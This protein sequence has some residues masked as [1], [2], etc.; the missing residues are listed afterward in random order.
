MI[1]EFQGKYRWLSNFYPCKIVLDGEDYNTVEHAYQAAKV[2]KSAVTIVRIGGKNVEKRVRE[3]VGETATPGMAKKLGKR[4]NLRTDW[5]VVKVGIMKDLLR[6]K[7]S[8][9]PFRSQLLATGNCQLVE[10]NY[11]G[12]TYWGVCN[13]KGENILGNL[14]MT[15]RNEIQNNKWE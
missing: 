11:W 10:G 8:Q 12:D 6:Q 2:D 13:G 3:L 1:S 7:F 15:I 5:E 4:L 14:I 9:E